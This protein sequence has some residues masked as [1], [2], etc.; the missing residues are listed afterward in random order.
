[1][2]Q[3]AIPADKELIENLI[4]PLLQ[5]RESGQRMPVSSPIRNAVFGTI[6]QILN[7]P[8]ESSVKRKEDLPVC[9]IKTFFCSNVCAAYSRDVF[10]E[11][12]GFAE[13][14]VLMKT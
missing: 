1:M 11:L 5:G 8:E 14:A 13:R 3:D 7:Y 10:E 6:H 12:G 4:R 2:T 9:G